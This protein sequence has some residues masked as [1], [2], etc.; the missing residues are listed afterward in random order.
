MRLTTVVMV[1]ALAA[2]GCILGH[3]TH[4][5]YLEA[6]GTVTWVVLETE[7]RSDAAD[8]AERRREEAELMTAAAAWS[9][10]A[11]Q[12]LATLGAGSLRREVVRDR[13]PYALWTEARFTSPEVLVR[14]LLEGLDIPAHVTQE[15]TAGG[16]R[17]T[18]Q[19]IVTEDVGEEMDDALTALLA[20]AEDYRIAPASGRFVAAEGFTLVDDGAA[21]VPCPDLETAISN[22]ALTL[23]L[24]WVDE[25]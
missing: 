7:L 1:L 19:L 15:R 21:A 13:R 4:H 24:E 3:T 23:A 22:G 20:D 11:A 8:P 18:V 2:S 16:A 9:H 17:L 10:P 5:I 14:T 6:D 12:A 25:P